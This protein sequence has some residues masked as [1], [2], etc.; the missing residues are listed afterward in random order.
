MTEPSKGAYSISTDKTRLDAE[1][2]HD[3]LCN[4]SYWAKG[5][6]MEQV[7]RTIDHSLCFGVYHNREQIGF[8][9]VITDY[10]T[11]SYL[12]DV[13]ILEKHRNQG[14]SNWLMEVI[15]QHPQ[16][17]GMRRFMLATR[18]AHKLYEKFGFKSVSKPER[19]MEIFKE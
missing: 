19:W 9:R 1:A 15:M 18:D 8:A 7:L 6:T 17:Q 13:Y 16:L 4:H 12:A 3:Y 2:I 11:F 10:T 5:R 14:L